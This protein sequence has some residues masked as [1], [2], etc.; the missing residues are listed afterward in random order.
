MPNKIKIA[1]ETELKLISEKEKQAHEGFGFALKWI[2]NTQGWKGNKICKKIHGYKAKTWDA[3]AQ[4]GYTK[5]RPLHA[6]AA[7]CWLS[8][9]SMTALYYGAKLEQLWRGF[10]RELVRIITYSNALNKQQFESL[11]LIFRDTIKNSNLEKDKEVD[12]LMEQL[13]EYPDE[14]FLIPEALD[15]ESFKRDYYESVGNKLRELR[16]KNNI[17]VEVMAHVIG[18]S[19]NKYVS[20][21]APDDSTYIPLSL[22][23]RLKFGLHYD[24]TT[25]LL[26]RMKKYRGFYHARYVQQLRESV[27]SLLLEDTSSSEKI[28]FTELAKNVMIFHFKI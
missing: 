10:D 5:S 28:A 19:V 7:F 1:T 12:M 11:I 24:N 25:E 3:Y 13:H 15:L 21:E 22:A 18:V 6:I 27:L 16:I 14:K 8:Q 4:P 20:F 23:M 17:A 9:V 2:Y 26:S